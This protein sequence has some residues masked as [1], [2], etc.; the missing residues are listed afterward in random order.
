MRATQLRHIGLMKKWIPLV[1]SCRSSGLSVKT[2]CK[3][4]GISTKTY[5]KWERQILSSSGAGEPL[6][7]TSQ[8]LEPAEAQPLM[9]ELPINASQLY[10]N[11]TAGITDEPA[12]ITIHSGSVTVELRNGA[13]PDVLN[14]VLRMVVSNA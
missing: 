7:Q 2:W 3:E 5:Y 10:P 14:Q 8:A 11:E 9:V 12:P 4:N 6:L 1:C 13:D